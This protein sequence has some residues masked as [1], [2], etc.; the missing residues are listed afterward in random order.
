VA[1]L[2]IN[3]EGGNM[4]Q[5]DFSE[6]R[7]LPRYEIALSCEE[8]D[9]A[10]RREFHSVT[11]D[12]CEQGVGIMLD[13]RLPLDTIVEVYLEMPDNQ[14]RIQVHGKV[15]WITKFEEKQFRAGICLDKFDLR[16]IPLVLRMIKVQLKSRYYQ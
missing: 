5:W 6:R 2:F 10:S 8:T 3:N 14:E 13:E 12:I 15:V 1:F 7:K 4:R 16:P 11:R 9:L